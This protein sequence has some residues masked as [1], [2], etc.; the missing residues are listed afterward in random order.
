M[1]S[2]VLRVLLAAGLAACATSPHVNVRTADA[3]AL[4]AYNTFAIRPDAQ[5]AN[6]DPAWGPK[7]LQIAQ[8]E[9]TRA[10]Q[11]QNYRLSAR[12]EAQLVVAVGTA[13]GSADD[14]AF[15]YPEGYDIHSYHTAIGTP[16]GAVP[17]SNGAVVTPH[18]EDTISRPHGEVRHTFVVDVF[19][20]KTQQLL[21]RGTSTLRGVSSRP[22]S[23]DAIRKGVRAI[24][25][26]FPGT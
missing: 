4:A 13:T 24:V 2:Q 7:D 15:D 8:E 16:V 22:I 20:A 9:L 23:E 17:V 14:V 6:N 11:D 1:L 10:L 5:S 25:N 3:K 18:S 19:D 26:R 12:A 21:W